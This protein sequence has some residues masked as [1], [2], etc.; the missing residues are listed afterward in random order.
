MLKERSFGRRFENFLARLQT[1]ENKKKK[2][3]KRKKEEER[4]KKVR[5]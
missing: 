5:K 3:R 4:G 1:K 2:K